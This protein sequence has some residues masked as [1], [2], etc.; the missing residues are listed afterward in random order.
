MTLVYLLLSYSL[1]VAYLS[2]AS[3]VLVGAVGCWPCGSCSAL[4]AHL[5]VSSLL[6]SHFKLATQTPTE[7]DAPCTPP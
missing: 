2:K 3:E 5:H 7:S 4:W 6:C 1:L